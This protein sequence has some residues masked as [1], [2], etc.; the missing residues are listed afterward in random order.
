MPCARHVAVTRV[1]RFP[2]ALLALAALLLAAGCGNGDEPVGTASRS[3]EVT[4]SDLAFEPPELRMARGERVE[5]RLANRGA[6]E[7]D[8][9][10][11]QMPVNDMRMTGGMGGGE[12]AGHGGGGATLHMALAADGAGTLAFEPTEAGQFEYYCTVEG[13]RA[14]GMVGALLVE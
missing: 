4:M 11:D 12:H 3:I 7:H 1:R 6:M 5:L 9:T 14:A 2:P 10:V 13:H 8:L